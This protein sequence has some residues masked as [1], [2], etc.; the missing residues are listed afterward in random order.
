[1]SG[2]ALAAQLAIKHRIPTKTV[3]L[4][5]ELDMIIVNHYSAKGNKEIW[6]IRCIV[7]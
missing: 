4:D 6:T 2:F 5:G 7:K 3:L 1:M